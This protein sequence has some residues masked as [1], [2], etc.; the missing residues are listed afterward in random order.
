M[1]F[2]III[3][4]TGRIVNE[5]IKEDNIMFPFFKL[6]VEFLYKIETKKWF[7]IFIM[8]Y[9]SIMFLIILLGLFRDINKFRK[10]NL[11]N[12]DGSNAK[13]ENKEKLI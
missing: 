7:S 5:E 6:G 4:I 11:K 3:A 10:L 13:G 1:I 12:S 2:F 8:V 9:G